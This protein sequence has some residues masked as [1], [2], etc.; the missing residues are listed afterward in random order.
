MSDQIDSATPKVNWNY[1][2]H[3]FSALAIVGGGTYMYNKINK[4]E[5]QIDS[6]EK[7][8]QDTINTIQA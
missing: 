2:A 5:K 8:F 1:V 6:Q 4:L 3:A 7:F